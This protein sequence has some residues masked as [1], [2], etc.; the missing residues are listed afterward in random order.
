MTQR[1]LLILDDEPDILAALAISLAQD[2]Q[3][4]G[5]ERGLEAVIA[6]FQAYKDQQPFEI[7]LLDCALPHFDGFTITKIV[8]LAE[9]TGIAR[10][11]K[12]ALFTGY[13]EIVEGS[14][15]LK[16][17]GADRYFR[18]PNDMQILPRLLREWIECDVGDV[19]TI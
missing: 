5:F 19:A 3:V 9:E 13:S 8:R 15:L 1:R 11:A 2:F 6:I 16:N 7:I 17:S 14:P 12:V 4:A 18:K 10:K